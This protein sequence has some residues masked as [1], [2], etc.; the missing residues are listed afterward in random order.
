MS[1]HR[2]P[3]NPQGNALATHVRFGLEAHPG[4]LACPELTP[5]PT[6]VFTFDGELLTGEISSGTA[7]RLIKQWAVAHRA[8]LDANWENMKAGRPLARIE[9]A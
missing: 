4:K 9:A 8:E 3:D 6:R 1:R 5:I 2:Q 7:L